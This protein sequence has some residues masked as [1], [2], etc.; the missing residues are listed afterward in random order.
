MDKRIYRI[1]EVAQEFNV[2]KRTIQ[3]EIARGE[4]NVIHIGRTVRIK[5]EALDD[6]ERKKNAT[7]SDSE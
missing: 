5:K 4:I 3:R 7:G 2:S 6:Y 1:D